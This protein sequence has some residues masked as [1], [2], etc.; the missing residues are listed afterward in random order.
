MAMT[1]NTGTVTF[2]SLTLVITSIT[3]REFSLGALEDSHLSTST[4]KTYVPEDLTE[5][6]GVDMEIFYDSQQAAAIMTSMSATKAGTAVVT[7]DPAA[8]YSTD[9][10]LSGTGFIDSFDPGELANNQLI[11]GNIGIKYDGK[12][13]P[14]FTVGS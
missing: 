7:L 12:T 13:G 1:G 6:G 10:N 4:F 3:P 14:T 5:P 2:D 9:P 11:R 8:A